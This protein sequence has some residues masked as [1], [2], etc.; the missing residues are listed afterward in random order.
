M[1]LNTGEVSVLIRIFQRGQLRLGE[2]GYLS[3]AVSFELS[4][5]LLTSESGLFLASSP[6]SFLPIL[7]NK[8]LPLLPQG[9][10]HDPSQECS[11]SWVACLIHLR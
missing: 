4:P 2:V 6:T 9:T 1:L 10:S 5:G 7:D 8:W 3:R 11:E